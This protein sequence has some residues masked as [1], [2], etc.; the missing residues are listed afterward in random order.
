MQTDK[1]SSSC[2]SL[3]NSF[4][5]AET[6]LF[7][8]AGERGTKMEKAPLRNYPCSPR[9]FPCRASVSE[10]VF[11]ES[12]S[13]RIMGSDAEQRVRPLGAGVRPSDASFV[14]AVCAFPS[15]VKAKARVLCRLHKWTSASAGASTTNR[16]TP[17][18]V[19]L[20]AEPG[21]RLIHCCNQ[22]STSR[23]SERRRGAR[24]ARSHAPTVFDIHL[25]SAGFPSSPPTPTAP[26]PA[27]PTQ[28]SI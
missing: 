23:E 2:C 21:H 4:P 19:C 25:D 14:R 22:T 18:T 5:S 8:L 13:G 7:T 15:W 17:P 28:T 6:L 9:N 10:D 16:A 24:G 1:H 20:T 3:F 26:A 12:K 27:P 11:I